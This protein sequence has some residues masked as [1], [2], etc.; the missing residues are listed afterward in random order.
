VTKKEIK[1]QLLNKLI[2]AQKAIKERIETQDQ[3][4]K[5]FQALTEH[6]GLFI[7]IINYFPF[8]ILVFSTDGT[9]KMIN[10]ALLDQGGINNE[11]QVV[12]RYN[13]FA[14]SSVEE[15]MIQDAVKKTLAGETVFLFDQRDPFRILGKNN[16]RIH[17][18]VSSFHDIVFFPIK[19]NGNHITHVAVVLLKQQP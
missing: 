7:Q 4:I 6:E 5:R 10:K 9:L 12:N 18:E 19:N 8:P 17:K 16:G 13:V 3:M 2:E 1:E 15:N 14:G 11:E